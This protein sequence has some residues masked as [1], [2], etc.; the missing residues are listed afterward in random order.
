MFSLGGHATSRTSACFSGRRRASRTMPWPTRCNGP[1]SRRVWSAT[2]LH[3]AISC[4]PSTKAKPPR[5][6]FDTLT[7]LLFGRILQYCRRLS[8]PLSIPERRSTAMALT[9]RMLLGSMARIGGA[10]AVYE[11]LAVLDFLRPPPALAAG[12][13]LPGDSGKGKSV[14]ILGA[15]VAGLCAAY[16]LDRAG[17]DCTIL[18]ASRR[19][20][21]RSLT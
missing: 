19:I 12:L 11:T 9:R 20:G 14:A 15:G 1:A 10:G 3:R 16:E 5:W 8:Q 7:A 17:Y 13:S 4:A 6:R 18:E 21:G 2:V